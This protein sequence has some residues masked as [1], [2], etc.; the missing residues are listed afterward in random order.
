MTPIDLNV[1]NQVSPYPMKLVG[2]RDYEFV[3]SQGITYTIGFIEDESISSCESYQFYITKETLRPSVKDEK[4]KIAVYQTISEGEP[5]RDIAPETV[6]DAI[7]VLKS[8]RVQDS[9]G[10]F[11]YLTAINLLNA[12]IKMQQYRFGE[13]HQREISYFF[14]KGKARVIVECVIA[15]RPFDNVIYYY[16]PSEKCLYVKVFD[17][18]FSF[19]QVEETDFVLNIAAKKPSF[20]WPGIK[21]QWIAE[22]VFFI[23]KSIANS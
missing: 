1:V 15:K 4:I 11:Y 5:R 14:I 16:K 13:Y 10:L 23:G 22:D 20:D 21:L 12:A 7:H 18:V 6:S 9:K 17:V 19:H 2:K 3:T 8:Y